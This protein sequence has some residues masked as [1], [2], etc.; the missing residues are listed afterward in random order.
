[1]RR[2][3]LIVDGTPEAYLRPYDVPGN[4]PPVAE[5]I[6]RPIISS[7]ARNAINYTHRSGKMAGYAIAWLVGVPV[8]ILL[9]IFLLRGCS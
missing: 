9:I 7:A 4:P 1:M 6:M 2:A 5:V 3:H 8:P